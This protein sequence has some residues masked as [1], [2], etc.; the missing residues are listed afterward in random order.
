MLFSLQSYTHLSTSLL[1]ILPSGEIKEM[2]QNFNKTQ[3][4]KI[5]LLSVKG[6]DE[7]ALKKM[8]RIENQLKELPLV[9]S[10][11]IKQNTWLYDHREDYKLFIYPIN[12]KN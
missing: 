2:L 9:S 8:Q 6:F 11:V 10:K 1:A 3:N 5:L 12:K 4:S 7:K